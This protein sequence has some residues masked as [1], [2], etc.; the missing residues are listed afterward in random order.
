[1]E[2]KNTIDSHYYH[3]SSHATYNF[4]WHLVWITKYRRKALT[5]EI[6]ERLKTI[7]EWV[8]KEQYIIIL[9]LGFEEDHVHCLVS[10]PITAY[11]PDV[12]RYLKGRTSKVIWKEFY[13]HLR[14]FYHSKFDEK[15]LW[16]TWYFFASVGR[17]DEATIQKYVENQ[18][19][20]DVRGEEITL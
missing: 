9:S 2:Q 19:K 8:C 15:H 6:I 13:K 10:L 16:A 17:V 1:M 12:I 20:E 3:H 11:I 14:T 4:T 5:P 18:W 7:I